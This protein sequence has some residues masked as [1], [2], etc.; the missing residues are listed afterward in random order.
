MALMPFRVSKFKFNGQF[1]IIALRNFL[2]QRLL[3]EKNAIETVELQYSYSLSREATDHWG[4][5]FQQQLPKLRTLIF[6]ERRTI[7]GVFG[8]LNKTQD[9]AFVKRAKAALPS[10]VELVWLC[11]ETSDSELKAVTLDVSCFVEPL[12]FSHAF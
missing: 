7:P 10:T 8:E 5:D 2:E 6:S 1:P 4:P 12:R 9:L 3:V 11:K